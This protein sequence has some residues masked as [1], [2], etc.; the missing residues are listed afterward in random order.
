MRVLLTTIACCAV[1]AFPSKGCAGLYHPDVLGAFDIDE[2]GN[3]EA[4]S[5]DAFF[6]LLSNV[7]RGDWNDYA[8]IKEFHRSVLELLGMSAREQRARPDR[9]LELVESINARKQAGLR[10]LS[11]QDRVLLSGDMLR[12]RREPKSIDDA[13]SLLSSLARRPPEGLEFQVL[14]HYSYALLL[15]EEWASAFE[16]AD[17]A[18]KDYPPPERIRPLEK[19]QMAW[20][21]R[22]ERDYHIPF[23]RHRKE[24]I[25]LRKTPIEMDPLFPRSPKGSNAPVCYVGDSGAFEPGTIADV[26]KAKLPPDA[27]AVMQQLVLWY[28]DDDRLMWQL[29]ELYN[30][31]GDIRTAA[32]LIDLCVQDLK[33]K[34]HE[35]RNRRSILL[36][37]AE[38]LAEQEVWARAEMQRM[39]EEKQKAESE[40]KRRDAEEKR[41]REVLIGLLVALVV[42]MLG[43]WQIRELVRRIRSR[44]S[45]A[46]TG[47]SPPLE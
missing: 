46:A 21:V 1:L 47:P 19:K 16:N 25:R 4:L 13:L 28:S 22:F 29:A 45:K 7:K 39:F 20:Y 17:S 27:L 12:L 37:I 10:N 30:A 36:P 15:K 42:L 44:R 24:E 6:A 8:V 40:K 38:R 26:E 35:I 34:N 18:I 2:N 32:R 5:P 9:Y 41:Q 23:L 43:Y 33:P 11:P 3:A 31:L 14:A